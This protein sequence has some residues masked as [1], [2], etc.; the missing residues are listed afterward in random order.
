MS[1]YDVICER[2]HAGHAPRWCARWER[3]TACVACVVEMIDRPDVSAVRKRAALVCVARAE[4]VRELLYCEETRGV[5]FTCSLLRMLSCCVELT[6]LDQA[7]EVMVQMTLDKPQF[8]D[9]ILDNIHSQLSGGGRL[10]GF[11]FLG[12]LMD[13]HPA[14]SQTLISS[15]LCVL[16]CVCAGLLVS[17]EEVKVAVCYVLFRIWSSMSAVH[18]LP[19]TLRH[20]MCV[21]L[22]HTLS[23]TQTTALTINC[24]GV[25]KQMLQ[26]SD[27]VCV[28][29][30][31]GECVEEQLLDQQPLPLIIKKLLLSAQDSVQLVSIRCVCAVLIYSPA[32]FSTSFIQADLPEFLFESVCSSSDMMMWWIFRCLLL[33]SEDPLFFSQCHSVYGIESLVRSLKETLGKANTEVQ[34]QGLELLIAILDRQPAGV[35]LFPTGS[36]FSAVADVIIKGVAS[37]CLQVS[38][39]AMRAAAFLLRPH[40]Q[41]RPV[42]WSEVRRVV[43][44]VL[45]KCSDHPSERAEGLLL[46]T[47][48]C[49]DAACRLAEVY[50]CECSMN[51]SV[52]SASQQQDTLETLCVYL[53]HCCDSTFIPTVTR[54]CERLSSP[55]LLQVFLSILCRQ[56]SLCPDH[57]TSFSRKLVSSGFI[58]L[59]L[60]NKAQ[61]CSE[62]RK[63]SLNLICCEFLIKLCMCVFAHLHNVTTELQDH[64][65]C[66]LQECLASLC[67]SVS[68]WCCVLLDSSESIRNTQYCIIYLLYASLLHGHM[69]LCDA[70]VFSSV[71]Q[72][73]SV[74]DVS[75]VSVPS[76]VQCCVVYLLSVTHQSCSHLDTSDVR[77][78]SK[79]LSCSPLLFSFSSV[80]PS[81]LSFIFCYP[82]LWER[83]GVSVLSGCLSAGSGAED[84]ETRSPLLQLLCDHPAALLSMLVVL[85]EADA[86]VAHRAEVVLRCFVWS[87]D[88]NSSCDVSHQ[89]KSAL[90]NLLQKLTHT[91]FRV[92]VLLDVL[93]VLQ[94]NTTAQSEMNNA[95]F[96][97]LYHVSNLV[98]KVN[99]SD[100]ELLLSVINCLYC[101]LS[102]CPSHCTDRVVSLLL[103]NIRLMEVLENVF[104]RSSSSS[105]SSLQCCSLLLLATLISLQHTLSAQVYRNI[106]VDLH[107]IVRQLAFRKRHTD[108]LLLMC[109][110]RLL[111]VWLDVDMC[112]L[113]CV[114]QSAAPV[115][116]VD[117]ALY[118]LCYSGAQMLMT[119]LCGLMLQKQDV[120][121]SST[122]NCLRSL[123]G[124]LLRR[125][126]VIA[127]HM[128]CQPWTRFLLFSLLSCGGNITLHP[129]VLTLITLLVCVGGDVSEWKTEVQSVCEEVETQGV[130]QINDNSLNTLRLL[131]TQCCALAPPDDLN[132]R[133]E[134]LLESLQHQQPCDSSPP[135]HMLCVDGV[136]VLLSD[137][138]VNT[139]QTASSSVL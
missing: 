120:M 55:Q 72:F 53:L 110:M 138:T 52:C 104:S 27:V 96:K 114:C 61:L 30:S 106:T 76:P 7:V 130:T 113:V 20:K 86:A 13:C 35:C 56:F 103:G 21:L 133:M 18:M 91:D 26:Y 32:R 88:S 97:L 37:S 62:N 48:A 128:V 111:Q 124:F 123:I 49:F 14:L 98:A 129:A 41:C 93:S 87:S 118:P 17:D 101:F 77:S 16:E 122:V 23:N 24:L 78:I 92:C 121:M 79:A 117:D 45:C 136:C 57:M 100:S 75:D 29:M 68:D 65:E 40:H 63:A 64:V 22:L 82:E 4:A 94:S 10:N 95:E 54:A 80:H 33:M 89:M 60:E 47:L 70:E 58:R 38:I 85:C 107:K 28:L 109:R 43:E 90:L 108:T 34:K 19:N 1:S 44:S 11:M 59:T 39:H 71:L 83:L 112:S 134:N 127:Q 51:D 66:V 42:Q 50:V 115:R 99:S 36:E 3:A 116:S 126:T 46:H 69:L 81:I 125:D 135:Q 67:C 9:F 137:F 15:H 12:K 131:L 102:V 5:N 73:I 31:V 84:G 74:Q 6:L 105:S 132:M 119:A 139:Q 2:I 25:L 8:L